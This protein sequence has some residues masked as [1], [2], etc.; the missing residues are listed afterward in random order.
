V[1]RTE[2]SLTRLVD[3]YARRSDTGEVQ[4][5]LHQPRSDWEW[6]YSSEAAPKPY[7]IASTTKL[8]T[9]ALILRLRDE[10]KLSLDDSIAAHLPS[11]VVR[12]LHVVDGVDSS[13]SIT[14]RQLLA[15][16]SGLANYFEQK[17]RDGSTLIDAILAVDRAWTFD[18]AVRITKEE[19]SPRFAPGAPGK[20]Y[21][22][23]TNY[24]LLGRIVETVDGTSYESALR[25]R[26]IDPLGLTSTYLFSS[27]TLDR[28]GSVATMLIGNKPANIPLAMASFWADGGLVSTAADGI[29]FLQAFMGAELFAAKNLPDLQREWRRIFYPLQYGTGLMKFDLPR[30]YSPL[31]PIP[32]MVGHSGASGTV[33]FYAPAPDLYVSGT[34]NQIRKRSLSYR[35]MTRI[36]AGAT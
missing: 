21:Y 28:T 8:Y 36:V 20:A 32:A 5:A 16:T 35:L 10:A 6:S 33:L 24:Q 22:S 29:I 31:R 30:F 19:M 12:G 2:E 7:F 15:H 27:D 14:V 23:D 11:D 4:F 13:D 25:R 34:V 17:R 26:I 18:E 1:K 9:T 3:K